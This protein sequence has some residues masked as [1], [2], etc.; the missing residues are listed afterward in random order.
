MKNLLLIGIFVFSSPLFAKRNKEVKL[1][2]YETDYKENLVT[3]KTLFYR[4]GVYSLDE[5]ATLPLSELNTNTDYD[6]PE[7]SIVV[8][9]AHFLI[10]PHLNEI[11]LEELNS[12]KL[13]NKMYN[14]SLE[15]NVSPTEYTLSKSKMLMSINFNLQT[16]IAYNQS[17]TD[18]DAQKHLET[19]LFLDNLI[20]QHLG[21][22]YH[23]L[24][25]FSRMFNEGM[26]VANFYDYDNETILVSAY[27]TL[28]IRNSAMKKLNKLLIFSSAEKSLKSE[29][30]ETLKTIFKKSQEKR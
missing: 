9:K 16:D 2:S 11:K 14:S 1:K 25:N 18:P 3:P 30:Y 17:F 15:K 19:T 13:I 7:Y 10:N 22:A 29:I 26:M 28:N 8:A 23:K 20:N 24:S 5:F 12:I 4:S 6:G 27:A 21:S